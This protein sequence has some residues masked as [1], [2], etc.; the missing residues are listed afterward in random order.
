M[1][2]TSAAVFTRVLDCIFIAAVQ[3]CHRHQIAALPHIQWYSTVSTTQGRC[4]I[5]SLPATILLLVRW[6]CCTVNVLADVL[7]VCARM[8]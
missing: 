8:G 1:A 6:V 4:S 3:Q 2:D 5:A 7:T